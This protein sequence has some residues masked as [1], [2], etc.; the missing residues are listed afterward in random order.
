MKIEKIFDIKGAS[1]EFTQSPQ[2]LRKGK[3]MILKYDYE[4][5][6]GEYSYTGITFIDVIICKITKTVCEELYMIE[7]YD[8]VSIVKNSKWRDE[9]KTTY[10]E[11]ESFHFNHYIIDF[12]D[13]GCYEFIAREVYDGIEDSL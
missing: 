13:Y 8:A 6:T 2:L 9:I 7:A 10:K 5:E 1:Q 3:N 4:I 11:E 12:E